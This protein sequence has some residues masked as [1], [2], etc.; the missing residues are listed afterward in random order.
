MDRLKVKAVRKDNTKGG[1][2]K[3]LVDE[4]TVSAS[5]YIHAKAEAPKFIEVELLEKGEEA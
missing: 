5:F 2:H 1:K 4:P 3:W